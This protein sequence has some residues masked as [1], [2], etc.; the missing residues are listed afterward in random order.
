MD[1]KK[2]IHVCAIMIAAAGLFAGSATIANASVTSISST[3][4]F[5]GGSFAPSNKVT[6]KVDSSTT[7]YSATSG[8]TTGGTRTIG[9]TSADPKMYWQS[10]A[11]N[12]APVDPTASLTGWT[13]L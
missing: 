8:H 13:S 2:A 3:V 1:I 6:V 11:K 9:T 10:K 5:G 7:A 4:T 12:A